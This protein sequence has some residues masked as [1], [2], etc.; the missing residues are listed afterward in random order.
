ALFPI[1]MDDSLESVEPAAA[2]S[3]PATPLVE[4]ERNQRTV[5]FS[6]EEPET[7]TVERTKT[8]TATSFSAEARKWWAHPPP[9]LWIACAVIVVLLLISV[10]VIIVMHSNYENQLELTAK[11]RLLAMRRRREY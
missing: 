4:Q 2:A 11:Y 8:R 5:A 10:I 6:A 3:S 7:V 9:Q 1:E